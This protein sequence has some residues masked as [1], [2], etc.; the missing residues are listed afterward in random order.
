MKAL[1][2]PTDRLA[3]FP[4]DDLP[5][6]LAVWLASTEA[7]FLHGRYL[8]ASWDV[9]ELATGEIRKRILE[10]PYFLKVTVAGLNGQFLA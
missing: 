7:A 9:N 3:L 1:F 8:W 4:I 2:P 5:G 6:S 10:D